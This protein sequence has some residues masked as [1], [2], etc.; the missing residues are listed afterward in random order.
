M[1][2]S[3]QFGEDGLW[4]NILNVDLSSFARPDQLRFGYSAGTGSGTQVYE[5]GNLLSITATAGTG[6]F[7]WDNGNGNSK[8]GTGANDPIDWAGNANPTLKANVIFNSSYIS[9]TQNIDLT[10]SDKVVKNLY[11]SG[12]NAYNLSTSESRKLI[13][14]S[15]TAGGL[16]TISVI[17]DAGGS[18]SHTLGVD[19]QMNQNLQVSNNTAAPFS[20]SG[21][22]D[23][24]GNILEAT[25]AGNTTF[26]GVISN[27]GSINKTGAGTV[28]LSGSNTYTGRYHRHRRHPANHERQRPRLH[29]RGHH[30][31]VWRHPRP[32]RHRHDVRRRRPDHQRRRRRVGRRPSQRRRHQYLDG[33]RRPRHG[34]QQQHRRRRR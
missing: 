15:E 27:T 34:W 16:T 25:G 31:A 6:Q 26:S 7:I 17:S 4:Y 10:G 18:A 30:R 29:R 14:D 9:S 13:M 8:W 24:G 11:F 5:V 22:V 1:A 23:T 3:M 20:I 28:T 2:V 21:N 12:A 33:H 19:V 32:S